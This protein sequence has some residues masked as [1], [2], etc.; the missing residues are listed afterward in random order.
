MLQGAYGNGPSGEVATGVPVRQG[1]ALASNPLLDGDG[2][3]LQPLVI[4]A[5]SDLAGGADLIALVGATLPRSLVP[6]VRAYGA[7]VKDPKP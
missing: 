1:S 6:P 5:E 4:E 2:R 3:S 7:L